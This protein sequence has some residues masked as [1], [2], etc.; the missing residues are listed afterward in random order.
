MDFDA[1][2]PVNQD[3]GSW[4]RPR[5]RCRGLRKVGTR[6]MFDSCWLNAKVESA[7]G[8]RTNAVNDK[9]DLGR[10]L[11]GGFFYFCLILLVSMLYIPL[12]ES[13]EALFRLVHR[14]RRISFRFNSLTP[15]RRY[16]LFR[17]K[18]ESQLSIR[19]SIPSKESADSSPIHPFD[20][21]IHLINAYGVDPQLPWG[22][23][24]SELLESRAQF[25]RYFQRLIFG[26]HFVA[27]LSQVYR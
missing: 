17:P 24:V 13:R 26:E 9:S 10:D 23:R 2:P 22:F 21:C 6:E 16:T 8:G 3:S 20:P 11:I 1:A 27:R 25:G 15:A 12:S 4:S 14:V 18:P 7:L 19:R 5:I